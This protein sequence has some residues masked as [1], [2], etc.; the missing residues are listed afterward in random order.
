MASSE[1]VPVARFPTRFLTAA[2][3]LTGLTQSA[4]LL[5]DNLQRSG[6]VDKG[7]LP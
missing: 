3:L 6:P 2:V 7:V 5:T 4:D 1:I